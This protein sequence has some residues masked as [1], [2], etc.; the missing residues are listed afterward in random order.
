MLL[1]QV[2]LDELKK[3]QQNSPSLTWTTAL[4]W[5]GLTVYISY[6]RIDHQQRTSFRGRH[7]TILTPRRATIALPSSVCTATSADVEQGV[8]T[9]MVG[10]ASVSGIATRP[11]LI[12]GCGAAWGITTDLASVGAIARL[13]ESSRESVALP[14][15]Q[16]KKS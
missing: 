4:P 8:Q 1:K 13:C 14:Q 16:D 7:H 2:P 3:P 9:E 11:G 6:Q 12:R 5:F 10:K 15:K